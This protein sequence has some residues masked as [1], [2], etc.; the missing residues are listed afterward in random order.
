MDQFDGCNNIGCFSV[1]DWYYG[2]FGTR[3]DGP[4]QGYVSLNLDRKGFLQCWL[5]CWYLAVMPTTLENLGL[6]RIFLKEF[7]LIIIRTMRNGSL[8]MVQTQLGLSSWIWSF[9]STLRPLSKVLNVRCEGVSTFI[10]NAM[11]H[12]R[13]N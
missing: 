12:V 11:Q 1:T 6:D 4:G 7:N 8:L 9:R 10:Y 2:I 13:A 5:D 3:L